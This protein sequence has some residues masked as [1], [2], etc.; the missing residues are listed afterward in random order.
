M[1]P[2]LDA[3]T[4]MREHESWFRRA[5]VGIIQPRSAAMKQLCALVVLSAGALACSLAQINP[6]LS[7]DLGAVNE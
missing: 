6:T 5:A 3:Q 7:P 4:E 1:P 2:S